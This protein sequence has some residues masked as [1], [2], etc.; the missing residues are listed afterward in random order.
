MA[1]KGR[2]DSSNDGTSASVSASADELLL[3]A[4]ERGDDSLE[5]GRFIVTFKE[6]ATED[7]IQELSGQAGGMRVASANDFED[8]AVSLEDVGDADAVVFPEIGAALVA[9]DAAQ[10]RDMT[11]FTEVASDSS[12]ESI[13]PELFVFADSVLDE[14][15]QG[16]YAGTADG[17]RS[18]YLR[19]FLHAAAAIAEDLGAALCRPA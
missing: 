1:T 8:G 9:G 5:T 7:A 10:A 17:G 11:A 13:D 14:Y 2:K 3:A 6:G 15:L 12:I 18:E 19:G 16:G 4:L